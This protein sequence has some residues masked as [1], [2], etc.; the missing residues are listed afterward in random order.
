MSSLQGR[1]WEW[2]QRVKSHW[3]ADVQGEGEIN[4]HSYQMLRDLFQFQNGEIYWLSKG[5]TKLLHGWWICFRWPSIPSLRQL[6]GTIAA[7]RA[8]C[9]DLLYQLTVAL[10]QWWFRSE[11]YVVV[12]SGKMLHLASVN[13]EHK[14]VMVCSDR[15]RPFA[16]DGIDLLQRALGILKGTI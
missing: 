10:V 4:S 2:G 12:S 1:S 15:G 6:F 14:G 7:E 3:I 11:H 13:M 9:H 5:A 8:M 16:Q